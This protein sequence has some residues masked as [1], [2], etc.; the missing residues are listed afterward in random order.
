MHMGLSLQRLTN[1]TIKS[2]FYHTR[3]CLG[4]AVRFKFKSAVRSRILPITNIF[5]FCNQRCI[6]IPKEIS[7][8]RIRFAEFK[9]CTNSAAELSAEVNSAYHRFSNSAKPS[10]ELGSIAELEPKLDLR[11][12][13]NSQANHDRMIVPY[14]NIRCRM[15]HAL[16][17][18]IIII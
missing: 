3:T 8:C 10:A 17:F 13:S 7:Y 2:S 18:A 14:L 16:L 12:D 15:M 4:L 1:A 9:G 5:Q 11:G 6:R